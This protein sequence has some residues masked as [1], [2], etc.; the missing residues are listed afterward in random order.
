MDFKSQT[1]LLKSDSN[2][3]YLFKWYEVWF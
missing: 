2:T 3:N 1:L